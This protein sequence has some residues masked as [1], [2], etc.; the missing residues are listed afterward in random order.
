MTRTQAFSVPRD[1]SD[2]TVNES[3]STLVEQQIS[4][5]KVSEYF[6]SNLFLGDP[7]ISQGTDYHVS[8]ETGQQ[9][10]QSVTSNIV[11]SQ[12]VTSSSCVSS[13][14]L[15]TSTVSSS[16]KMSKKSRATKTVSV[17][18]SSS[19][20]K[21]FSGDNVVFPT[22]I[23]QSFTSVQSTKSSQSKA[24][25]HSNQATLISESQIS[26]DNVVFP[27]EIK[28]SFASAQSAKSSQS[29]TY[30]QSNQATSIS[31]LQIQPSNV[32]E[33]CSTIKECDLATA[34]F[35]QSG[36]S[37]VKTSSGKESKNVTS[38]SS[39]VK[40]TKIISETRSFTKK[41]MQ[42]M[43]EVHEPTSYV[44]ERSIEGFGMISDIDANKMFLTSQE[45]EAITET[46]LEPETPLEQS[47]SAINQPAVSDKNAKLLFSQTSKSD[48]STILKVS[49]GKSSSKVLHSEISNIS[50]GAYPKST[51]KKQADLD[52]T[53]KNTKG[54]SKTVLENPINLASEVIPEK[55]KEFQ[56]EIVEEKGVKT[57]K[58][59]KKSKQLV[60]SNQ[61]KSQKVKQ[62][63]EKTSK[64]ATEF[65]GKTTNDL[66]DIPAV[67]TT[68][69][70]FEN[71]AVNV[72]Q[73]KNAHGEVSDSQ[74]E[75]MEI[76]KK[77]LRV[78][79]KS[80]ITSQVA[81][82]SEEEIRRDSVSLPGSAIG[83]E[84]TQEDNTR[85]QP[86][87]E[88]S[89][90]KTEIAENVCLDYGIVENWESKVHSIVS[91]LETSK[92]DSGSSSQTESSTFY[93]EDLKG[94]SSFETV[95]CEE[96][97]K[98]ALLP[99]SRENLSKS[100]DKKKR[101]KKGKK[102][103]SIK[104]QSPSDDDKSGISFTKVKNDDN[105][106]TA[107]SS[108]DSKN[109]VVKSLTIVSTHKK[110]YEKVSQSIVTIHTNTSDDKIKLDSE[111]KLP[112]ANQSSVADLGNE[113]A[114]VPFSLAEKYK[115]KYADT[116]Q[117]TNTCDGTSQL[118]ENQLVIGID[119]V[120]IDESPYMCFGK[121]QVLA[122]VSMSAEVTSSRTVKQNHQTS[123]ELHAPDVASL[124]GLAVIEKKETLHHLSEAETLCSKQTIE[125]EA[126]PGYQK[127]LDLLP[128]LD[129]STLEV[130]VSKEIV[131]KTF[132]LEP[133]KAETSISEKDNLTSNLK[134]EK[135]EDIKSK[136]NKKKK[137]RNKSTD[138]FQPHISQLSEQDNKLLEKF[139]DSKLSVEDKNI[140]ENDSN[141]SMEN[142]QNVLDAENCLLS[143]VS[144]TEKNIK[145]N[146]VSVKQD[147]KTTTVQIE[148]EQE[149][150][151]L[152]NPVPFDKLLNLTTSTLDVQ[153]STN[154][155]ET[156]NQPSVSVDLGNEILILKE[157]TSSFT[158]QVDIKSKKN[159]K[160]KKQ[161][162]KL[163]LVDL[164][165]SDISEDKITMQT[166]LKPEVVL[167]S[168]NSA[169]TETNPSE[170][171]VLSDIALPNEHPKI[172]LENETHKCVT[173]NTITIQEST[174]TIQSY[175]PES[176]ATSGTETHSE[177]S[178]ESKKEISSTNTSLP[179]EQPN[180]TFVLNPSSSKAKCDFESSSATVKD[181][182]AA[183][184]KPSKQSHTKMP[185][186]E[187]NKKGNVT[188]M[189]LEVDIKNIDNTSSDKSVDDAVE[190]L[191]EKEKSSD[192]LAFVLKTST[193]NEEADTTI[194]ENLQLISN[195]KPPDETLSISQPSSTI[196][197]ASLQNIVP[198]NVDIAIE[199]DL[200]T[201]PVV[202]ITDNT[203]GKKETE[204]L[205][206]E[207][208]IP[209]N[210]S[211][212]TNNS[213]IVSETH[214]GE[215]ET[216]ENDSMQ[217]EE[218]NKVSETHFGEH[219][220]R[221]NSSNFKSNLS[222]NSVISSQHHYMK[223]T[224]TTSY[225]DNTTS[226][227][228]TSFSKNG[229]SVHFDKEKDDSIKESIKQTETTLIP[230]EKIMSLTKTPSEEMQDELVENAALPST[231]K[232]KNEKDLI[233]VDTF[234]ASQS[235]QNEPFPK[236]MLCIEETDEKGK[237]VS[238]K[239]E[240]CV[241]SI[242]TSNG[243]TTEINFSET[244]QSHVEDPST[245]S[246]VDIEE[247]SKGIENS[248][249]SPMIVENNEKVQN[250]DYFL[251][252]V[253][254]V[255]E[256]FHQTECEVIKQQSL[257]IDQEFMTEVPK[258]LD[259][260]ETDSKSR[261]KSKKK[262]E[263]AKQ[264]NN[265][266]SSKEA[267]L[268]DV[269]TCNADQDN[270]DSISI[271]AKTNSAELQVLSPSNVMTEQNYT[272]D[273]SHA[274]LTCDPD[275]KIETSD[276]SSK[277]DVEVKEKTK[278]RK[279][280]PK[281]EIGLK[282]EI[283]QDG[284]EK[285][286][287][288]QNVIL[289]SMSSLEESIESDVI[290]LT[291]ASIDDSTESDAILTTISS[292]EDCTESDAMP[293]TTAS[294][295]EPSESDFIF[296]TSSSVEESTKGDALLP[297]TPL[298]N[299]STKT[300]TQS[301]F[302]LRN[303]ETDTPNKFQDPSS[304]IEIYQ[305]EN[306]EIVDVPKKSS[307]RKDQPNS[308]CALNVEETA[309]DELLN[310]KK[311]LGQSDDAPTSIS[312][313]E[314][315]NRSATMEQEVSENKS[316][317][318]IA[319]LSTRKRMPGNEKGNGTPQT[320]LSTEETI[321]MEE[322]SA[323][324]VTESKPIGDNA[325]LS[326]LEKLSET[327]A[328]PTI[329]STEETIKMENASTTMPL[330]EKLPETS[331]SSTVS[332]IEKTI[333]TGNVTSDVPL[334][335]E[336]TEKMNMSTSESCV[337]KSFDNNVTLHILSPVEE[338]TTIQNLSAD[339]VM[340]EQKDKESS[341]D[342]SLSCASEGEYNISKSE[343]SEIEQNT[344]KSSYETTTNNKSSIETSQ[345]ISNPPQEVG[346]KSTAVEAQ[347]TSLAS[348][349]ESSETQ[350]L[351]D[352]SVT[353]SSGKTVDSKTI[354]KKPKRK[355]KQKS[356]PTLNAQ[357]EMSTG[358]PS[359]ISAMK[360]LQESLVEE[361]SAKLPETAQDSEPF[362]SLPSENINF[363]INK[364]GVND[365]SKQIS[366]VDFVQQSEAFDDSCKDDSKKT[367][368]IS[369]SQIDPMPE[370]KETAASFGV[371]CFFIIFSFTI[372]FEVIIYI[373]SI[374]MQFNIYF[375]KLLM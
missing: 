204:Q 160:K 287:I 354:K 333:E 306:V 148:T 258:S 156:T 233:S 96:D 57:S 11:K 45:P 92:L 64:N 291:T 130:Q 72:G 2:E 125:Q 191:S 352:S 119:A 290:P 109:K 142:T 201:H 203:N 100:N 118:D 164:S 70:T 248:S 317:E 294:V 298:I 52:P 74:V 226:I 323:T 190:K 266:Q 206:Q 253:E 274:S 47:D 80:Q 187:T 341:A 124:S 347:C 312:S 46:V 310:S 252:S 328:P 147:N 339:Y 4:A 251:Q 332:S 319:M 205:F 228:N 353:E 54:L 38:V 286:V 18:S 168:L 271:S 372:L 85:E 158:K 155:D 309:Q 370:N 374:L 112:T 103:N 143:E 139:Q 79:E 56:A 82:I 304:V 123:D 65:L 293:L 181:E 265:L 136:K 209:E 295:D 260:T 179:S 324:M 189:Q 135:P 39:Q 133:R 163:G 27:T 171:Y 138:D 284:N 40:Q 69:I 172:A 28:Q 368:F 14:S 101:N 237:H 213:N 21:Q 115:G 355:R 199:D 175:L 345:D 19:Q 32:S 366:K 36:T 346:K 326:T 269:E 67:E 1:Q 20:S 161:N 108:T 77:S 250:V 55:V 59:K 48:Q 231:D 129:S 50:H 311:T 144:E 23:K 29:K 86:L 249:E 170:L 197:N 336:I 301:G 263:R 78:Q 292:M 153:F 51:T 120:P 8:L 338:S 83:I 6:E 358:K 221:D 327:I 360:D 275:M 335:D 356:D 117:K 186:K 9:S 202:P 12:S 217:A 331:A 296:T 299:E 322:G 222:T 288:D 371:L 211:M 334:V 219:E 33:S 110:Q 61:N 257:P 273:T 151:K 270:V 173:E 121:K 314:E 302:D 330:V 145:E 364:S 3:S 343:T 84:S 276:L 218:S 26:D 88:I 131:D 225:Q 183:L 126:E 373:H 66:E 207:I 87:S 316:I 97:D 113:T 195:T 63:S 350:N 169:A 44:S 198:E 369:M 200:V 165:N 99:T 60:S 49:K 351:P 349:K 37:I 239:N 337:E 167:C 162:S 5:N 141:I 214:F 282:T 30:I 17:T 98:N 35:Q 244:T 247:L 315:T 75:T 245:K 215:H 177:I 254:D 256:G 289:P 105:V 122:T 159:K 277:S 313:I 320:I 149:T 212:Q 307:K 58:A 13:S 107:T 53:V 230:F 102:K 188:D 362:D 300:Q 154:T 22:D 241:I 140:K 238:I 264:K 157:K 42:I 146:L 224:V 255:S 76:S 365:D 15:T 137:N 278:K 90:D 94:I 361:N 246:S 297:T 259:K 174:T 192:K 43:K 229:K 321:K 357:S 279:T 318:N 150:T 184:D 220:T 106:K 16:H 348:V 93:A 344:I 73:S 232:N 325:L 111:T 89:E 176:I 367:D 116:F 127:I 178:T 375:F 262:R 180:G 240:Q 25:I 236:D 208:Y 152:K 281:N 303:K 91:N 216:R 242:T 41:H 342:I 7:S 196:Q 71:V 235:S 272:K 363:S 340:N 182:T 305:P 34:D 359:P 132:D 95:E 234:A 68:E 24:V 285:S 193:E 308:E 194:S 134:P 268:P 62:I 81:F 185:G 243:V 283:K 31:H 10:T 329:S 114:N 227:S 267:T 166:E 261:K 223:H 210:D 128:L 104:N 280:K